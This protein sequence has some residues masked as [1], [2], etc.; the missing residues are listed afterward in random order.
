L[1][2]AIAWLLRVYSVLYHLIL[3]LFCLGI[4]VVSVSIGM[5]LRLGMLPWEG[6]TLTDAV[7]GLSVVGLLCVGLYVF[8]LVRWLFVLWTL[9]VL[10]LMFRGFF[11]SPYAFGDQ[12]EF[13]GAVWLTIGALGAFLGSLARPSKKR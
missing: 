5:D 13:Q 3:A 1:R 8:G 4:S 10:G 2:T 9:V 12:K 6:R 7:L 11:L